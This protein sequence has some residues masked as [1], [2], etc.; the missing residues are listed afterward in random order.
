MNIDN[1][2]LESLFD[3]MN[4]Y[5]LKISIDALIENGSKNLSVYMLGNILTSWL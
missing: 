5:L 4:D 3:K 2:K 1:E